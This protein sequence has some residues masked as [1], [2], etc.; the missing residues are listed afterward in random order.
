MSEAKKYIMTYD[1]VR[2]LETE[3]E[4][5]KTVRRKEITEKI[6]VALGYGD[7]SENSEYDEAK[8]EQA[9]VEG[10]IG[11]LENM[12]KNASVIDESEVSVDSV[13]VGCT[14]K[15]YDY[16][17]EEEVEYGIVGST[18]ADPLNFKISNESPVG[19][20]LM[21]HK[22]GDEVVAEVPNGTSK[23]KIIEIGRE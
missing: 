11:Q 17:F 13:S 21:G 6:K 22:V 16:E 3:L 9:F 5:L 20:A 15:V 18:E 14:V 23:F 12:L 2:K 4:Y 19:A 10:R 1:G 7:L 8:N